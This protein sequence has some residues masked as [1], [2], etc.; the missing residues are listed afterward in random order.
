MNSTRHQRQVVIL[1]IIA[2]EWIIQLKIM[3]KHGVSSFTL[4]I[5]SDMHTIKNQ[6][7]FKWYIQYT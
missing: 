4:A 1:N 2:I 5:E 3:L 7:Y 6:F